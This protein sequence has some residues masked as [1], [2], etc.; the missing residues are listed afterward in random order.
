MAEVLHFSP[1][2]MGIER[3]TETAEIERAL[4]G[5]IMM[6][7]A[8]ALNKLP[9]SFSSDHYADPIHKEVHDAIAASGACEGDTHLILQAI[10]ASCDD[11]AYVA[12]LHSAGVSPIMAPEYAR[13]VTEAYRRRELKRVAGNMLEQAELGTRE[14]PSSGIITRAMTELDTLV[15]GGDSYGRGRKLD[16]AMD[17]ALEIAMRGGEQMSGYT[18]GMPAVDEVMGGLEPCTFSILAARPGV[19][20]TALAT[21]WAVQVARDAKAQNDG[22]VLGFSLEMSAT[23]LARRILSEAS[24]ISV[25]DLKRGRISGRENILMSARQELA[26]LPIWIED[27]GGMNLPAIR[28]KTRAAVR[29]YGRLRLIWVDH[30]QI[31]KWED[32]DRKQGGTQAIGRISNQLRD[33]AKEFECPVLCLSQL[34]RQLLSR[35]D[36]RPNLGD[37]RQAGDIEQDADTVAFLHREEMYLPKSPPAADGRKGIADQQKQI[38]DWQ[39]K[40]AACAGKAELIFE[41]VRDGAPQTVNL[42]FDG[43]TTSF[44]EQQEEDP[45]WK[46]AQLA[47]WHDRYFEDRP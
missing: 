10:T 6:N 42:T 5:S 1:T 41:K 25:V 33:L 20:K 45:A 13:A 27:A 11:R 26:G 29:R 24:R 12:K 46:Q 18:T 32:A 15:T 21:Q 37:L 43:Q 39:A 35:D 3:A 38:D 40:K 2:A 28:Q 47:A 30:M 19:G 7:A 23:A 14:Y 36:K 9:A 44:R 17:G 34:S 31:V 16:T 4:V 22:G 8:Y